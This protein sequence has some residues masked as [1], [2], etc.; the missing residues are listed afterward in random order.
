MTGGV[1]SATFRRGLSAKDDVAK[2]SQVLASQNSADH[3]IDINDPFASPVDFHVVQS[4][5]LLRMDNRSLLLRDNDTGWHLPSWSMCASIWQGTGDSGQRSLK[6]NVRT[7]GRNSRRLSPPCELLWQA[8]RHLVRLDRPPRQVPVGPSRNHQRHHQRRRRDAQC[9]HSRHRSRPNKDGSRLGPD[10]RHGRI[11]VRILRGPAGSS[12]EARAAGTSS[13]GRKKVGEPTR[14]GRSRSSAARSGR[15]RSST[16][17]R[18]RHS[19]SGGPRGEH[20]VGAQ[21]QGCGPGCRRTA[22]SFFSSA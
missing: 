18:G 10:G 17:K 9:R 14:G 11:E 12:I 8:G 19:S 15:R 6:K 5:R 4:H 22:V 2:A 13:R 20:E 7:K 3:G 1:Q 21:L 16:T